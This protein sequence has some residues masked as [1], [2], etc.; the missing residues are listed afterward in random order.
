MSLIGPKDLVWTG[1]PRRGSK[2]SLSSYTGRQY[3][4]ADM[5]KE[6]V[7][8]EDVAEAELLGRQSSRTLG[9][10]QSRSDAVAQRHSTLSRES[11]VT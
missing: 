3:V 11:N 7:R 9:G 4:F 8:S 2:R 10:P 5:L 6:A 1:C